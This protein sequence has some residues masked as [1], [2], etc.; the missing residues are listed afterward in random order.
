MRDVHEVRAAGDDGVRRD[1]VE[2][3]QPVVVAMNVIDRHVELAAEFPVADR[4]DPPPP[5]VEVAVVL[6][7]LND[8]I[9]ALLRSGDV[10]EA[11]NGREDRA[12]EVE[13]PQRQV[14]GRGL[15]V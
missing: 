13:Q 1:A 6:E 2:R 10:S 12:G 15:E 3:H 7:Q 11:K 4:R 8:E 14:R 5:V 9:A